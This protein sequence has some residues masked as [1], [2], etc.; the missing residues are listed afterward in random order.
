MLAFV[1]AQN[2]IAKLALADLVPWAI[3]PEVY[4]RANY[5][6][7]MAYLPKQY[8]NVTGTG[9]TLE[10]ALSAFHVNLAEKQETPAKL[11]AEA[12]AK[13]EEAEALEA[14]MG[15]AK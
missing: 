7:I 12:A 1:S 4:Y 10:E 5:V 13:I 14:Q 15:G 3:A 11:R 2:E 8:V 6:A 9:A